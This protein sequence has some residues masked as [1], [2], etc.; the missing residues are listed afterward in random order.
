MRLPCIGWTNLS[1]LYGVLL[2]WG[3]RGSLS[4]GHLTLLD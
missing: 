3:G 1:T 4:W 2:T